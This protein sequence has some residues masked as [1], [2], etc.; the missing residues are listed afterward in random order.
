MASST[1][2]DYEITCYEHP[3]LRLP[4]SEQSSLQ[5]ELSVFAV[6]YLNPLPRY[7]I[8]D[9]SSPIALD[10]KIIVTARVSS[11]GA[12]AAF[13]SASLIPIPGLD[14]SDPSITIPVL[15]T[16]L[17]IIHH[18]HRKS[19]NV[20]RLLFGTLFMHM[21]AR[22]PRGMWLVSLAEVITSLVQIARYTKNCFPAPLNW[23]N[24][25][26]NQPTEIHLKIAREISGN[27]RHK[28]LISKESRFDE[29]RFVFEASNLTEEGK[30]FMKDVDDE[31]YW[32][33]D[34]EATGFF[35]GFFRRNM[36]DE[37]LQVGWLE[38]EHV[39]GVGRGEGGGVVVAKL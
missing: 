19:H 6:E 33:R 2:I 15:N 1:T 28:F 5:K 25:A 24:S 20:K 9:T 35:R 8:F 17:T 30:V 7:N 11:T 22:F 10:D 31:R 14:D 34:L 26:G 39:L 13:V 27:H 18:A 21:F 4:E 29:E 32:H 16:G 38:M 3:G 37:V 23:P 36:G 12:L